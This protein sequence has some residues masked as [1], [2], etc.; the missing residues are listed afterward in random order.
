MQ[1]VDTEH[2]WC[3]YRGINSKRVWSR[4]SPRRTPRG[5]PVTHEGLCDTRRFSPLGDL[6]DLFTETTQE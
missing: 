1:R 3:F 2:H 5:K 6:K 4:K